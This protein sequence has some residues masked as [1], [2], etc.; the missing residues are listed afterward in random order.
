MSNPV[1]GGGHVKNVIQSNVQNCVLGGSQTTT[2]TI[3]QPNGLHVTQ[4]QVLAVI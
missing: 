1:V 2:E 4:E 3:L